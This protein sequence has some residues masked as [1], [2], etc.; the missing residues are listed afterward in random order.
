MTIPPFEVTFTNGHTARCVSVERPA[1]LAAALRALDLAPPRPCLVLV[2][3]AGGLSEA[4]LARLMP[5]FTSILAP[6]ADACG[7]VVL[8]GGT[9][10]GVMRLMGQA[11]H[12]AG[13]AFPLLGVAAEGT[14]AI[15]GRVPPSPQAAP[16]EPRHTHFLLVPGARWGDESPWLARVAGVLAG[17]APSV[18]V[19]VNGGEVAFQDVAHSIDAGRPVVVAAGTG[20]TADTLAAA[21]RG[22]A[23]DPRAARLAASGLL[24][25]LDPLQHPDAFRQRIQSA[26]TP[27]PAS[28]EVPSPSGRSGGAGATEGG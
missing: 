3:G 7:A 15:P 18:T 16:L 17:G 22:R 12:Q 20:R 13:A 10:S 6:A 11:R 2:G 8:D 25:A 9:D 21:L 4:D 19:L 24:E 1:D 5:L 28:E 27:P 26:L 23:A 14:V